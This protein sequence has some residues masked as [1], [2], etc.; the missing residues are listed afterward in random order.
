MS[1]KQNIP[2]ATTTTTTTIKR[3]ALPKVYQNELENVNKFVKE[4]VND[5]TTKKHVVTG[6][7]KN[8]NNVAVPGETVIGSS[9]QQH[10]FALF[11]E[12][13]QKNDGVFQE[14]QI[15]RALD[16]KMKQQQNTTKNQ[17]PFTKKEVEY[18]MEQL[19]AQDKIMVS[20]GEV[21][22]IAL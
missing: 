2:P 6:I 20:D 7:K 14:D 3:V 16:Q 17:K 11:S 18:C 4:L 10:F 1:K 21:Y 22:S 12:L 5:K 13:L 9:R 15:V 19:C 8:T